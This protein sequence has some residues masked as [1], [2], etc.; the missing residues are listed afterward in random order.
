[1]FSPVVEQA[2]RV[3]AAAHAGQFRKGPDRVHYATHPMH[4]ALM[5]A[6]WGFDDDVIAAGLLHDVVEDCESWTFPRV[7]EQF[8][9]HIASIVRQLTE[10]ESSPWEERKRTAIDQV[11]QL[12]PE[13]ASVKAV[14]KL[15]NLRCLLDELQMASDPESVW[16]RYTASRERTLAMDAELVEALAKRTDSRLGRALRETYESIVEQDCTSPSAPT[17]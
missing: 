9:T 10:D 13:A 12:S 5:L 3:S 1:M 7:E 8:G 17:I 2:L 11:S 14:D 16:A 6:K 4:V 15:H